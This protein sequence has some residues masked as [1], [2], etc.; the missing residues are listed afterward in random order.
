M[1]ACSS[2]PSSSERRPRRLSLAHLSL[3]D[4]APPELIRIAAGAGY[5]AVGLRLIPTEAR[6]EP[7]HRLAEN[8]ALLRETQLA[9]DATG[10]EVLDIEV[11]RIVEGLDVRTF[12]PAMEAGAEL[13]A[14]FLLTS[15]WTRDLAMVIDSVEELADLARP[16][17]LTLAFEPVSFADFSTLDQAV[18]VMRA[19]GSGRVNVRILV[20]TLHFHF[21]G[22]AA[23]QITE[24]PADW[25][26]YAHITDGPAKIPAS[27]DELRRI[28]REDRLCPGEGGID[29]PG[30]LRALPDGIPCALEVPNPERVK[31]LGADAYAQHLLSATKRLLGEIAGSPRHSQSEA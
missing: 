10:L 5:D 13:G 26:P 29:L 14:R 15:A 4:C 18:D 27:R 20:D 17:G 9:L 2:V 19:V 7:R 3:L 21:A 28:A 22:C 30:I 16:M 25:F 23:K 11:A 8:R 1:A 6:N 24:L 12:V 31:S